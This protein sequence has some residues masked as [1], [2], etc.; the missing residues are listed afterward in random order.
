MQVT[1]KSRLTTW[2]VTRNT[3]LLILRPGSRVSQL[4]LVYCPLTRKS[5]WITQPTSLI[6]LFTHSLSLKTRWF[7]QVASSRSTSQKRLCLTR[8]LHLKLEVASPTSVLCSVKNPSLLKLCLMLQSKSRLSLR[9]VES[10]I[11]AHSTPQDHS[12][13]QLTTLTVRAWS[14]S[15]SERTSPQQLLA[16]SNRSLY[17]A[18]TLLTELSMSTHLPWPLQSLLL[19]VTCSNL[20]SLKK[21]WSTLVAQL[22][23]PPSTLMT[24]SCAVFQAMIFKSPCQRL[25]HAPK[26]NSNGP[27][28]TSATQDLSLLQLAS[29]ESCLKLQPTTWFLSTSLLIPPLSLPTQPTPTFRLTTSSKTRCKTQ[30]RITTLSP[31][32]LSTL[33]QLLDRS[34]WFT[35]ARFHYLM[36]PLPSASWPQTGSFLVT[37]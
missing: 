24:R 21:S 4:L 6:M 2:P 33:Y 1:M 3:I 22:S 34:S 12:R 5:L 36:A 27:W 17:H 23:A 26:I 37:A 7:P 29:L 15:D 8:P 19:M 18:L 30:Q 9:S 11:S 25:P 32:T 28:A 13:S 20:H 10:K 16:I 14:M 31:S 35:L